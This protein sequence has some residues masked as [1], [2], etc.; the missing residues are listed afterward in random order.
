MRIDIHLN[1]LDD[2]GVFHGSG[3]QRQSGHHAHGNRFR[4][5]LCMHG[6]AR[7][8]RP[9]GCWSS[10]CGTS[11]CCLSTNG[12]GCAGCMAPPDSGVDRF[13]TLR[14]RG[15]RAIIARGS[16]HLD[17]KPCSSAGHRASSSEPARCPS[18]TDRWDTRLQPYC[19][20]TSKITCTPGS[21]HAATFLASLFIEWHNI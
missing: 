4:A 14:M 9:G 12:P 18:C 11:C 21:V 2:K 1:E 5:R 3:T 6:L 8:R 17:S 13:P 15:A 7:T 19:Q 10:P 16:T 20:P